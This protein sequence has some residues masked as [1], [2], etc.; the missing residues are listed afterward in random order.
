M[1]K[2]LRAYD[3][4]EELVLAIAN[5]Y[6]KTRARVMSSN[7]EME[8]FHIPPGVLQGDTLAPYM[9]VIVLDYA[10][11]QAI[12]KYEDLGFIIDR[13]KSWTVSAVTIT[14]LVFADE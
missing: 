6:E 4:V 12:N 3:F 5:I 13:Q 10:M 1:L 2:I 14:F 11:Q 7:G 8:F 9:F